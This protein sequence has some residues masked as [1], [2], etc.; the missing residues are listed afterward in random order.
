MLE[1]DKDEGV[2]VVTRFD[3]VRRLAFPVLK[4][5]HWFVARDVRRRG[6]KRGFIGVHLFYD[7]AG[8]VALSVSIWRELEA[9]RVMGE[10]NRHVVAVRVPG[11][12][13]W[14]TR[15]GVFR[16]AGDWRAVL[17]AS[18][19]SSPNPLRTSSLAKEAP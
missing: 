4:A 11:H 6:K 5:I 19:I 7:P 12:F 13:G 2:V 8:Q 10:V 14:H 16:F 3:G 15:S 1:P 9:V 17:F 18:P